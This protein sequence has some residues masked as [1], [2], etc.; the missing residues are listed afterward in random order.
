[1]PD[2]LIVIRSGATDYDLQGRLRGTLDMPLSAAGVA[3]ATRAGERLKAAPPAAIYTSGAACAIETSRIVGRA[4]GLAPRRMAGLGNLDLGL[5]QGR[6]IDE[7]REKQPRLHRQWRDNPWSVA[8]PE[9]ELLEEACG[10][11]EAALEKL[12]KRHP[13]GRIALVV[14]QPLD[15]VV[16][17]LVS[18]RSMDDLWRFDPELDLVDELPVAAQ[19]RPSRDRDG[20]GNAAPARG[21]SRA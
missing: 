6:L 15:A 14:P 16:R 18:G 20:A 10:R 12:V 4:C 3:A 5:W 7:I 1:M 9:G 2:H 19:W 13:A 11:V 17:W 8:P 21:T